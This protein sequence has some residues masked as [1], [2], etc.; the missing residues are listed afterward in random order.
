MEDIVADEFSRPHLKDNKGGE[1]IPGCVPDVVPNFRIKID[2]T[3]FRFHLFQRMEGIPVLRR[4][5]KGQGETRRFHFLF[6]LGFQFISLAGKEAF[7]RF[8]SGHV[9]FMIGLSGT[10]GGAPADVPVEARLGSRSYFPGSAFSQRVQSFYQIQIPFQMLDIWEW[11]VIGASIVDDLPRTE[12]PRVF[13]SGNPDDRIGFS[14]FQVDVVPG[15][16]VLDEVV[17]KQQ[18]LVLVGREDIVDGNHSGHEHPGLDRQVFGKIRAQTGTQVLGL[19]DIDDVTRGVFHD[20][21]PGTGGIFANIDFQLVF[22]FHARCADTRKYETMNKRATNARQSVRLVVIMSLIGGMISQNVSAQTVRIS[23]DPPGL[24]RIVLGGRNGWEQVRQFDNVGLESG[25]RGGKDLVITGYS[26]PVETADLRAEFDRSLGDFDGPYRLDQSGTVRH[27]TQITRF[28]D[29]AAAFDGSSFLSFKPS[30]SSLFAPNTQPG[31]FVVDIWVYPIR[32][33]E[34]AEIFHWNGALV[35]GGHPVLQEMRLVLDGGRFHWVMNNTV[36]RV[37]NDGRQ[38]LKNVTLSAR[39]GPVPGRWTHHRLRYDGERSQ[40][41]YLVNG[42]PEAITYLTDS[43]RE[44]GERFAVLLG[45]DTG[46]GVMIGKHFQGVVDSLHIERGA[47]VPVRVRRYT[48]RPGEFVTAPI[49]LGSRGGDIYAI[50]SRTETPGNT[51][52]RLFYR[53]GNRFGDGLWRPVTNDG[54]FESSGGE[55]L[56]LRGVL[57]NDASHNHSPRLQELEILYRPFKQ[58]PVPGGIRGRSVPG[59]VEISWDGVFS[60]DVSGYRVL[61]GEQRGRY[62]GT[63]EVN[64]PI[65]VGSGTTVVIDNL[66]PDRSYVFVVESV[67]R[68]GQSSA[69]SREIEVR[70]GGMD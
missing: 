34:G 21:Y 70:A 10:D 40:L 48:G 27:S 23:Q 4:L 3:L 16:M 41:A 1:L 49:P 51:E 35:F 55:Y 14:V 58:P 61:F 39:R 52:V 22:E 53:V 67:N 37:D 54:V 69:L 38:Q 6:Q 11:S 24:E 31:S 36:V 60:K 25:W 9:R 64:S 15:T 32:I 17:F 45:V 19:A 50:R 63:P 30:T 2:N 29:G 13:F 8:D 46:E 43:G 59:G 5:F 7:D 57:L 42:T 26:D 44:D 18:R 66:A 65:S 56:Q 62:L 12:D 28:G 20:V 68:Y 47:D 33:T